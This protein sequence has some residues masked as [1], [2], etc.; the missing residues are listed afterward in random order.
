MQWE[1]YV[2]G[3]RPTSTLSLVCVAQ[4]TKIGQLL[5]LMSVLMPV[6][7]NSFRAIQVLIYLLTFLRTNLLCATE[8]AVDGH[9]VNWIESK[10]SFGDPESHAGYLKDQFWSYWNR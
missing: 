9:V 7:M 2:L 8:L 4:K 5:M 1:C 6:P 3:G 10:A